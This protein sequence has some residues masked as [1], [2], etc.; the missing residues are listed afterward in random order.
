M[1]QIITICVFCLLTLSCK[2]DNT[3]ATTPP[4]PPPPS[5]GIVTT[6]GITIT[7][8]SPMEAYPGD[9]LTVTGTGFDTDITKDSVI[10]GLSDGTV[11]SYIYEVS[12]VKRKIISATATEIKF[13]VDSLFL[14]PDSKDGKI[15]LRV[16]SPSKSGFTKDILF[17]KRNLIFGIT[18]LGPYGS[19]CPAVFSGD[20]VY[21]KGQGF[22]PPFTVTIDGMQT[23][24][25]LDVNSTTSARGLL[26][27]GFF[28]QSDPLHCEN[29]KLLIVKAVNGDGRTYS[30]SKA[31]FGA[32][33]SQLNQ[34]F[35]IG[36]NYSLKSTST[37]VFNLT[38]YALRDDYNIQLSSKDNNNGKTFTENLAIPIPA[39]YPNQATL[40]IDLGAFP[41]P[42]SALGTDVSYII[43]VGS[44]TSTVYAGIGT[45]FTLY[46]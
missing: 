39:G 34:P 26:P 17:F 1:R 16:S 5:G 45:A 20:S 7:S 14:M 25:V 4:P 13:E 15:A 38:G 9:I 31:F 37:A 44:T 41:P 29:S 43:R 6:S 2:K 42:S 12:N 19:A 27:I 35:S 11:F 28:A 10:F 8:V 32:P 40:T 46:P 36:L 18:N 33:N 30:R 24:M 23:N 3:V 22:Y 21:L